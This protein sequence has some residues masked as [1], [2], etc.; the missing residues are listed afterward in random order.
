M[1]ASTGALVT[2]VDESTTIRVW[3]SPLISG[4]LVRLARA[5]E[6]TS[7]SGITLNVGALRNYY[8]QVGGG[9]PD[10]PLLN[11]VRSEY[12]LATQP[13]ITT[14]IES[15]DPIVEVQIHPFQESNVTRTKAWAH[16]EALYQLW[17]IMTHQPTRRIDRLG[18]ALRFGRRV[19]LRPSVVLLM[20][21]AFRTFQETR[22]AN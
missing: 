2:R 13:Q 1:P 17:L 15:T 14:L 12:F 3:P 22:R 9:K 8:R 7:V 19:V 20:G 10:R 18:A 5:N 11:G 6:R 16:D 4:R 21:N